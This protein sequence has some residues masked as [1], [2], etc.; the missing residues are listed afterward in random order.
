[1]SLQLGMGNAYLCDMLENV[2]EDL[3]VT[4]GKIVLAFQAFEIKTIRIK[5]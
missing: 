3:E 2:I 4:D 1:M 5:R